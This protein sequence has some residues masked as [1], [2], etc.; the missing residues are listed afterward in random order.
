MS[1]K[2]NI[3]PRIIHSIST[4]YNDANRVLLEFIDNSIDSAEEYL[5]LLTTHIQDQLKLL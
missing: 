5:N 3:S 1:I 4:L 2:G